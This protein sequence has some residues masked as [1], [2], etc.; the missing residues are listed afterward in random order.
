[1][2][3]KS[4]TDK[5]LD[6]LRARGDEGATNFELSNISLNYT[7]CISNCYKMGHI[8][9]CIQIGSSDTYKYILKK[10]NGSVVYHP[11]AYEDF[12]HK[13]YTEFGG[14]IQGEEQLIEL[15]NQT[16]INMFRKHGYYKSQMKQ[17]YEQFEQQQMQ[18]DLD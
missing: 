13:M 6:F 12:V 4:K 11:T 5:I 2:V 16:G 3:Y 14:T 18:F 15:M 8:I 9:Q 17:E 1:M 7:S 10:L